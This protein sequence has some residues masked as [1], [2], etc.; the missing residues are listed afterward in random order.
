MQEN[1]FIAIDTVNWLI[2]SHWD[3]VGEQAFTSIH[4]TEVLAS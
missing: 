4:Q 3:K 1:T 2:P